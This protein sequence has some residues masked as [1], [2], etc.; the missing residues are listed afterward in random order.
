MNKKDIKIP[1]ARPLF[2]PGSKIEEVKKVE[3]EIPTIEIP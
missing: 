3:K 1:K 2:G